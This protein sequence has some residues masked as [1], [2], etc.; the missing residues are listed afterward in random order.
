MI[1]IFTKPGTDKLHG[2]F[3]FYGNDIEFNTQNPFTQGQPAYHSTTVNGDLDGPLRKNASYFLS[4]NRNSSQTN[5]VVNA[6][7][8]DSTL[9][10]QVPF[11]QALPSPNTS[12]GFTPRIDLQFGAKSTVVLRYSYTDSEQT[13]GGIGQLNLPSQGFN[14]STL[15]QLFQASNSQIINKNIVNDTRFQYIRT[16]ANQTPMSTAPVSYTHLEVY[17]ESTDVGVKRAA[18]NGLFL[19]HDA[20]RLVELARGEKDLSTKRDIVAQLSLMNDSAA[21][22][23]MAELLK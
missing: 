11:T 13:N 22:D 10:S 5:A 6:L 15:S 21:I 12:I 7:V 8:L 18:I 9:Q 20:P 23:Y 14:S 16:R 17:R 19:I 1:E 3:V 2:D 4:F